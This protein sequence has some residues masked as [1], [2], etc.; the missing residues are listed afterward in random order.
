[1]APVYSEAAENLKHTTH[2]F[3]D[4]VKRT[5][6]ISKTISSNIHPFAVL[7]LQILFILLLVSVKNEN[8]YARLTNKKRLDGIE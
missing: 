1:M 7:R 6:H 3:L 5:L 4:L 2:M 8:V